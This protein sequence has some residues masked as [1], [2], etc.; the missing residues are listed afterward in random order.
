ME[1]NDKRVV[2]TGANRGLGRALALA[3][4]RAGAREVVACARRLESLN[5]LK[6]AAGESAAR[7][8]A[9]A[10]DVRDDTTIQEA[11][12]LGRADVLINNAGVACF[13]G[14]L[15]GQIEAIIEEA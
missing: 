9:V 13:G 3:C 7:L 2:I 11:A 1:I 14:V 6:A 5:D 4:L 12:R 15:K 8:T 10:L